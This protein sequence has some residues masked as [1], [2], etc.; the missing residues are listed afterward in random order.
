MKF[1]VV[2]PTM[3][4]EEILAETLASLET[5]DPC[6]DEVIVVDSDDSGSSET[7]VTAFDQAVPLSV[8]YVRTEP[9]LTRQRNLGIE[10]ASGD[11]VVF[12]DDDVSVPP[13]IFSRLSDVYADPSIVGATGKVIEPEAHKRL[14]PQ[15][16]LRRFLPGGG[17][18]GTFTRFG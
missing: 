8:H 2:I 5:C 18:E 1:S 6:P 15:S 12:F 7:V 16:S 13:E 4:R 9:S 3:R 11:V 14:G 10:D 17:R